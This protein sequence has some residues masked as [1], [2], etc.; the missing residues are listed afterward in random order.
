MPRFFH[1]RRLPL[2]AS[3][4]E[5]WNGGLHRV[6][7]KRSPGAIRPLNI[8]FGSACWRSSMAPPSWLDWT[9]A[10]ADPR[11]VLSISAPVKCQPYSLWPI[12]G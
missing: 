8:C 5:L 2:V 1:L 11:A 12:S 3:S 6:T 4:R 9:M 7:S 10:R